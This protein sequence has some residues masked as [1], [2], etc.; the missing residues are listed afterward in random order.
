MVRI[1]LPLD[2][3]LLQQGVHVLLDMLTRHTFGLG[4]FGNRLRGLD[5]QRL[6]DR[7]HRRIDF[8]ISVQDFGDGFEPVECRPDFSDQRG[9]A[10]SVAPSSRLRV[11]IDN[12]GVIIQHDNLDVKLWRR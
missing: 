6:K 5:N 10:L 2:K 4:D 9:S 3:T 1:V 11:S 7:A 8:Q 12:L